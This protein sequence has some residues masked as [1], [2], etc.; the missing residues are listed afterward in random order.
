MGGH[1][2]GGPSIGGGASNGGPIYCHV[3]RIFSSQCHDFLL[4][5]RYSFLS[6]EG[7]KLTIGGVNVQIQTMYTFERLKMIHVLR[8]LYIRQ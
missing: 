7:K 5:A 6:C 1:L 2:Y 8:F 3:F 4:F